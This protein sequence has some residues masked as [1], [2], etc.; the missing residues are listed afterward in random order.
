MFNDYKYP[1]GIGR[2]RIIIAY[3]LGLILDIMTEKQIS[4]DSD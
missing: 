3:K 2:S 1:K 4:A